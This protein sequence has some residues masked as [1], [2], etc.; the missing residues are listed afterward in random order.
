MMITDLS[1]LQE[2]IKKK[3][4][5]KIRKQERMMQSS[6]YLYAPGVLLPTHL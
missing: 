3:E 2:I 5:K 6:D 1:S 4:I